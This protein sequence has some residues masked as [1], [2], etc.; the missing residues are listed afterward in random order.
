MPR[1]WVNDTVWV[2]PMFQL[3]AV[4][5]AVIVI[6]GTVSTSETVVVRVSVPLTPVIVS[7]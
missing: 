5:G 4:F 7:V 1:L 6:A 2:D 3:T